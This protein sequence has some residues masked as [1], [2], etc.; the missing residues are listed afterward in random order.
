MT[1]SIKNGGY[2]FLIRLQFAITSFY[3][4]TPCEYTL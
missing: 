4:N 1:L 2:T 3:Y